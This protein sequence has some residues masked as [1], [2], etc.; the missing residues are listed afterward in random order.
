M[1]NAEIERFDR[2]S[3]PWSFEASVET[4]LAGFGE[5]LL[6]FQSVWATACE[7][8]IWISG[9]FVEACANTAIAI[10]KQYPWLY[11]KA[12]RQI[13]NGAAYQWR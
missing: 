9:T 4:K 8:E 3:E 7:P 11:A 13:A 10:S 6:L 5:E 12:V 1:I 2:W